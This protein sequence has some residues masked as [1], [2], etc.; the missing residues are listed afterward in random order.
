[1]PIKKWKKLSEE[2]IFEHPR[3]TLIEDI[4]LLPDGTETKYLRYKRTG[5]VATIIA[6]RDDG[7]ILLQ[8][9]YSHPPA[10][11]LYQL[12]GGGVPNDE[13][14]A[15]GANRELME[16]CKLCGDMEL[17]GAYY[18]DNRRSDSKT[19]VFVATNLQE[20]HLPGDAEEFIEYDWYSE[21]QIDAMIATGAMKQ[22][23]AL[24]SWMVYKGWK[25]KPTLT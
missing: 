15:E 17:I 21:A 9:E 6:Q 13:D 20:A 4:V 16:E 2:T 25:S 3:L 5:N 1:M 10:E 14:V 8:R 22:A 11:V 23:Y 19:Y 7:L 12:P 18:S 24:A